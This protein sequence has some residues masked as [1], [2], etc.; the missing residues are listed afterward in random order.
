MN[1]QQAKERQ[2]KLLTE[3][4]RLW[5]A[6]QQI[7]KDTNTQPRQKTPAEL[8]LDAWFKVHEERKLMD[9]VVAVMEAPDETV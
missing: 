2:A 7:E 9:K 8:A 6:K 4:Q 3:E 1:L 5:E